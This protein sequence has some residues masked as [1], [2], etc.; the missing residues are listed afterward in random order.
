MPALPNK[1][2]QL[3]PQTLEVGNLSL[4]LGQMLACDGVHRFAGAVF[5]IRQAEQRAH[6]IQGKSQI[7]RPSDETQPS[8]M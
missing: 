1:R 2:V 4:D 6:L 8:D 3:A 7:A 5:L